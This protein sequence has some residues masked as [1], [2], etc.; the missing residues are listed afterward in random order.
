MNL[1]EHVERRERR[2]LN[3][4]VSHEI[5]DEVL[6][7]AVAAVKLI[8]EMREALVSAPLESPSGH[9]L[10]QHDAALTKANAFLG[11]ED[12]R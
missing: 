6:D 9:Y 11:G 10:R 5:Y 1:T 7:I 8:E 3:G 12:G 4:Y 2:T